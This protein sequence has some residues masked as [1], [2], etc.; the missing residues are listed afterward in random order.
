MPQY[1]II[2]RDGTDELALQRRMQ[3]RPD[4]LAGAKILKEQ[5]H[6]ISGGALLDDKG[7]MIGS[8]MI[9]EFDDDA[10]MQQWYRNEPYITGNVWQN[11]EIKPFRV[12]Q[13]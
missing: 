1:V 13:V 7:N 2:A 6:L 3:T 10:Q 4:H 8:V 11:I 5:K 9:L 12:A